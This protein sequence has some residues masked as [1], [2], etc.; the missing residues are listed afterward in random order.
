MANNETI[1]PAKDAPP[2]GRKH[3][4]SKNKGKNQTEASATDTSK[5]FV[6]CVCNGNLSSVSSVSQGTH[7]TIMW[8]ANQL[9]ILKLENDYIFSNLCACTCT[10]AVPINHNHRIIIYFI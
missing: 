2:A 8:V 5:C 9:T 6:I 1:F 3:S 10:A 4:H 7:Y